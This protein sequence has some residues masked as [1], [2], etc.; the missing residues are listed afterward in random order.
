MAPLIPVISTSLD[1]SVTQP[2]TG[3]LVFSTDPSFTSTWRYNSASREIFWRLNLQ[4][5]PS[6]PLG[7]DNHTVKSFKVELHL[8]T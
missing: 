5:S 7:S 1:Q 8:F 3:L 4:K 2:L 6:K